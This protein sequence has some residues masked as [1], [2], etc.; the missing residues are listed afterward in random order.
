[1]KQYFSNTFKSDIEKKSAHQLLSIY[2]PFIVLADDMGGLITLTM[3]SNKNNTGTISEYDFN[4]GLG[5]SIIND[6][7]IGINASYGAGASNE[8]RNVSEN[9]FLYYKILGGNYRSLWD[10]FEEAI[11]GGIPD[12][13][14]TINSGNITEIGLPSWRDTVPL[15]DLIAEISANKAKE[16]FEAYMRK[17]AAKAIELDEL[18]GGWCETVRFN[19]PG[20]NIVN[21]TLNPY[22]LVMLYLGN[23]SGGDQG[24]YHYKYTTGFLGTQVNE[25]WNSGASGQP[26]SGAYIFFQADPNSIGTETKKEILLKLS[27]GIGRSGNTGTNTSGTNGNG[28]GGKG[29]GSEDSVAIVEWPDGSKITL[30]VLGSAGGGYAWNNTAATLSPSDFPGLYEYKSTLGVGMQGAIVNGLKI[31]ADSSCKP[32]TA[33]YQ[34]LRLN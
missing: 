15:W 26:G 34:I 23:S 13:I 12:A 24:D 20:N 22:D 31:G 5:V 10:T 7:L 30:N 17:V 16:V 2:A 25:G 9:S 27:I 29:S 14:A 28:Q 1:L 19:S 8:V 6:A 4:V 33:V 18:F 11:L 32:G 3:A 21:I